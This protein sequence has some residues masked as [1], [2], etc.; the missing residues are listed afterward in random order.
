MKKYRRE[1]GW[2]IEKR[3][4]GRIGRVVL[5]GKDK[6]DRKEEW[7]KGR[8]EREKEWL[9]GVSDASGKW[10]GVGMGGGLWEEGK[11][12][13]EWMIK[14]G[15]GM[16]VGEG[17][18]RGV[19]EVLRRVEREYEDRKRKLV[20]GVDN[21]GVLERLRKGRGFCG[22][23]EQEV[24][25]VGKRLEGRGWEIVWEWVPGHVGIEEDKEA[26][27]LA[28]RALKEE[29]RGWIEGILVWGEWERRRK[30]WG[31]R[32]WREYWE[33]GRKRGAYFGK[34]EG[35]ELGHGGKRWFSRFL[36]W[37]RSDHGAMG[38]A[39]CREKKERCECGGL[40]N[41]DHL[42]LECLKWDGERE[43]I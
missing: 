31:R 33:E 40:D 19:A 28:K 20:V 42:L 43:R 23:M 13:K 25:K 4:E 37:I 3:R 10:E 22:E 26:D 18:M 32:S 27:K 36:V 38:A 41:R 1:E 15:G 11:K 7:E 2:E 17:E 16:T 24:R 6:R 8:G 5:G 30:E 34:G 21:K 12:I 35:G 29:N 14:G 9:V 39:R